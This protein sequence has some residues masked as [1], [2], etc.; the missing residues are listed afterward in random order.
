MSSYKVIDSTISV[1]YCA[2]CANEF[3]EIVPPNR[4][5]CRDCGMVTTFEPSLLRVGQLQGTK[6]KMR[7]KR[8]Y[9]FREIA[10]E[11]RQD[12]FKEVYV[13]S[14]EP[15]RKRTGWRSEENLEEESEQV[16]RMAGVD[17]APDKGWR[18]E[19]ALN[20]LAA[21]DSEGEDSHGP[22]TNGNGAVCAR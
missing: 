12:A 11:A 4:I 20:I 18:S 10:D 7:D 2:K 21:D 15:G 3:L 8:R 13:P 16:I 6:Y 17:D 5:V 9:S 14:P 19:E 1:L 22:G